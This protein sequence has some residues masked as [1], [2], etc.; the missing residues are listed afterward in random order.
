VIAYKGGGALDTV[1][2][3]VT[4]EYFDEQTVD[5]L[6]AAMQSFDAAKYNPATIRNHALKFDT[7]IFKQQISSFV[8]QAWHAHQT[9]E[10]QSHK[11]H[12]EKL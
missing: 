5:S 1:I 3:G 10:P 12:K 7:A 4:G 8:G 11:G 6:A 9:N 2:E